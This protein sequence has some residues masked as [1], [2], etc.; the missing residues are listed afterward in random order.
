M[1]LDAEK[2]QPEPPA[3]ETLPQPG[4]EAV[5]KSTQQSTSDPSPC[6][7]IASAGLP[8]REEEAHFY[9]AG[10][11]THKSRIVYYLPEPEISWCNWKKATDSVLSAFYSENY[12]GRTAA[13]PYYLENSKCGHKQASLLCIIPSYNCLITVKA[14]PSTSSTPLL[15]CMPE[16]S[17]AQ[18]RMYFFISLHIQCLER[19]EAD[20]SL[21]TTHA[22]T[23]SICPWPI[24]QG[25]GQPEHSE[26]A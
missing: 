6:R 3:W 26:C 20:N 9:L 11:Q 17:F 5:P 15:L 19:W 12:H 13:S 1:Q 7:R 25:H 8:V 22:Q 10:N 18:D 21:E 2:G 16:L 23:F 4:R 14:L 24:K